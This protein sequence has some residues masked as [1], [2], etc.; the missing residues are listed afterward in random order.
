LALILEG[1]IWARLGNACGWGDS[2][3]AIDQVIVDRVRSASAEEL[4][5]ATQGIVKK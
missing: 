1:A 4:E 5:L 3:L 2:R